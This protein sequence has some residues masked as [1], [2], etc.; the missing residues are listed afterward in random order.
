[1]LD[2]PVAGSAAGCCKVVNVGIKMPA[3]QQSQ[4]LR[5]KRPTVC[6]YCL[7]GHSQMVARRY[8][9]QKVASG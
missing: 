3:A 5:L 4:L 6:R 7:I 2:K 8:H 9:H 1:M